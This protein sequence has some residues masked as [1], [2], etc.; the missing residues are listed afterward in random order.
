MSAASLRGHLSV[1][2]AEIGVERVAK[3]QRMVGVAARLVGVSAPT[4]RL[5]GHT[6]GSRARGRTRTV[7]R[8]ERSL[9]TDAPDKVLAEVIA[10][11]VGHLT[12]SWQRRVA[13]VAAVLLSVPVPAVALVLGGNFVWFFAGLA[14]VAAV[15][16][17]SCRVLQDHERDADGL[18]RWLV[19]PTV[20]ET[21]LAYSEAARPGPKGKTRWSD[22]HLRFADRASLARGPAA[23]DPGPMLKELGL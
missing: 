18:A 7:V 4:V 3:A 8:L 15:F 17:V 20:F 9:V 13:P 23:V 1:G 6:A 2:S 22:P 11:E 14:W 10:H 21:T 19:G 16:V 12:V 5:A